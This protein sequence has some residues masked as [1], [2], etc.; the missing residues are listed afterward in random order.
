LTTRQTRLVK[1]S[2]FQGKN[3]KVEDS[4]FEA[5]NILNNVAKELRAERLK[6][7]G[8]TFDRVEV[9]FELK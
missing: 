6:K 9:K 7:G 1:K 2:R 3:I 8:I 4:C 5:L